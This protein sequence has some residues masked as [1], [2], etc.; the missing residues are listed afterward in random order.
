M[1]FQMGT[2]LACET[3]VSWDLLYKHLSGNAISQPD[4]FRSLV[5]VPLGF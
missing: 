4:H 1:L 2:H 3:R 5:V